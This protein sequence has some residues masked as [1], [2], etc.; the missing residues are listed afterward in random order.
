MYRRVRFFNTEESFIKES[1]LVIKSAAKE[2]LKKR[3]LFHLV[4]SGGSTPGRL[5]RWMGT[6]NLVPRR[7]WRKTHLWWGD[8][9]FVPAEDPLSNYRN[10]LDI[11]IRRQPFRDANIHPIPTDLNTPQLSASAYEQKI[12][13]VLKTGG[14]L[15]SFDLVLLG[16]GR[17]G[18]TASLFPGKVVKSKTKLVL[19]VSKTDYEPR[20]A[21]V[22]L[23]L[24]VL[25][26][27]KT[28]LFLAE[29]S[30]KEALIDEMISHILGNSPL[31]A[32]PAG[33]VKSKEKLYFH[34]L[35]TRNQAQ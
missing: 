8:E 26:E 13:E 30:G 24:N 15:P 21:R 2:A 23:S 29:Y 7:Y 1:A 18:H 25:N 32:F 12:R 5:Y 19:P 9:R 33:Q 20:V 10:T 35:K 34:I 11:F 14:E 3:R 28:I 6:S 22:S 17:D 16:I 31:P 4:L 27:A